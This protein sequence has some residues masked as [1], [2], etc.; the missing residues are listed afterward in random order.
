MYSTPLCMKDFARMARS[1]ARFIVVGSLVPS[2][3]RPVP[4]CQPTSRRTRRSSPVRQP[5]V[6]APP[7]PA[8]AA[9][10]TPP[11][12]PVCRRAFRCRA[13]FRV[14]LL[15]LRDQLVEESQEVDP[16]G[17]T[18]SEVLVDLV[19][20]VDVNHGRVGPAFVLQELQDVLHCRKWPQ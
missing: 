11:C 20:V 15:A 8:A 10:R 13:C 6:R 19:Q 5:Y 3:P 4:R 9:T 12:E 1:S 17:G 18:L 7:W 14:P 16:F 2:C